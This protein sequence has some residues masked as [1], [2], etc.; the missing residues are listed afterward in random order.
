MGGGKK[1]FSMRTRKSKKKFKKKWGCTFYYIIAKKNILEEKSFYYNKTLWVNHIEIN[2]L[3]DKIYLKWKKKLKENIN[4]FQYK[5]LKFEGK[6]YYVYTSSRGVLAPKF[7]LSHRF[8]LSF[9][10]SNLKFLSKTRFLI[11]SSFFSNF[12]NGDVFS[13]FLLR[14]RNVYT[15][16]GVRLARSRIYSKP[17]KVSSYR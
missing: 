5:K 6:G 13:F 2:K 4:T 12:I 11:Y 9:F 3:K 14:P 7:G 17:G 8:Y 10:S 15:G 16:R 1:K